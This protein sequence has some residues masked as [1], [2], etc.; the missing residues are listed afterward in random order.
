MLFVYKCDYQNILAA[1]YLEG[2]L[3]NHS[4]MLWIGNRCTCETCR[5][6]SVSRKGSRQLFSPHTHVCG[7]APLRRKTKARVHKPYETTYISS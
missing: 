4:V 5:G 3:L 6:V 1:N 7:G 2:L